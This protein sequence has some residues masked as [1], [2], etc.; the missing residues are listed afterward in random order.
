[1]AVYGIIYPHDD[2]FFSVV[3][4]TDI[5]EDVHFLTLLCFFGIKNI[6]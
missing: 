1:M 4:C 5:W 3:L 6:S 2:K